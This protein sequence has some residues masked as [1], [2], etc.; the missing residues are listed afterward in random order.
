[1][2]GVPCVVTTKVFLTLPFASTL[3][4]ISVGF[5]VW[6]TIEGLEVDLSVGVVYTSVPRS[7]RT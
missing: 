1:M 7:A 6:S 2:F 4:T 5:D 3:T